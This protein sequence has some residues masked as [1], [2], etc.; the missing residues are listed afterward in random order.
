MAD[1]EELLDD[2]DDMLY[3][4]MVTRLP[5]WQEE[6]EGGIELSEWEALMAADST[7]DK[8]L[9]MQGHDPKTGEDLQIVLDGGAEWMGHPEG[10]TLPFWWDRGKIMAYAIDELTLGKVKEIAKKLEAT[11]VELSD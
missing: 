2:D 6:D 11:L 7:L 1:D 8:V 5:A 10:V 3:D 9:H 4:F